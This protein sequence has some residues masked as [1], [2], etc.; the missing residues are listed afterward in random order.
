MG[1]LTVPCNGFR[2]QAIVLSYGPP[3]L[4]DM[5][6][7]IISWYYMMSDTFEDVVDQS[8][9]ITWRANRDHVVPC[10][11]PTTCARTTKWV[12]HSHDIIA[13]V[14]QPIKHKTNIHII[15]SLSRKFRKAKRGQSPPRACAR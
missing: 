7:G 13:S 5:N 10:D 4:A 12:E 1:E 14:I 3:K 9:C 8:H 2:A 6:N 15:A 11:W